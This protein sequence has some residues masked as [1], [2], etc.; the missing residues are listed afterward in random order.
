MEFG[1]IFQV[2]VFVAGMLVLVCFRQGKGNIEI[3]R[4]SPSKSTPSKKKTSTEQL[5]YIAD[6]LSTHRV[7]L[8]G[9]TK[10]SEADGDL[11]EK[12]WDELVATL[13]SYGCGP[14]KT[15]AQWKKVS[16]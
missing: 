13:N 10:P 12:L 1:E 15:K 7:M 5:N 8:H 3:E 11:I 9:K 6:F 14:K 16:Y 4:M 2:R